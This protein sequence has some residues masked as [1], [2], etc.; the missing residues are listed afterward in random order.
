M[1]NLNQP[2]DELDGPVHGE[3]YYWYLRSSHYRKAVMEPAGLILTALRGR[4]TSILD[5]GCGE[6]VLGDYVEEYYG[7][8]GSQV[9]IDKAKERWSDNRAWM[10]D[11]VQVGRIEDPPAVRGNVDVVV[12]GGLLSVL[13]DPERQHEFFDLYADRYRPRYFLVI[14]IFRTEF[15]VLDPRLP[16]GPAEQRA[17]GSMPPT[18]SRR[19]WVDC[20]ANIPNLSPVKKQRRIT[21]IEVIR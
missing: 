20:L 9:A 13:V 17:D 4:M 6:A 5:V 16:G 11:R 21:L 19:W 1:L 14:D 10:L 2:P 7:F 3:D 8:D 15:R 18:Y 12:F